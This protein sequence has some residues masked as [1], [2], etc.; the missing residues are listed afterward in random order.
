MNLIRN[1]FLRGEVLSPHFPFST[2]TVILFYESRV[3]INT[4]RRKFFEI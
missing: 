1:V 4:I 2:G 3:K